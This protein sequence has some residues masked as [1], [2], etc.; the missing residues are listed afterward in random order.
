MAS[1]IYIE[2]WFSSFSQHMFCVHVGL[3]LLRPLN[4]IF[5]N[6]HTHITLTLT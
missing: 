3:A 4:D 2:T 6:T 1:P 5:L